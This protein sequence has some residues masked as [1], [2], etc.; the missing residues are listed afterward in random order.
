MQYGFVF[1][2]G[3]APAAVEI[4]QDAEAAGWDGFSV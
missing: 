4:A 2:F 3:D 1:P